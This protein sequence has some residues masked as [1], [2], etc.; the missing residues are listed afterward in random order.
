MRLIVAK[1]SKSTNNQWEIMYLATT[2]SKAYSAMQKAVD[3]QL[4]YGI[5]EYFEFG[6]F[7]DNTNNKAFYYVDYRNKANMPINLGLIDL[8]NSDFT[9]NKPREP[10]STNNDPFHHLLTTK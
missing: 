5:D 6:V 2:V 9:I 10:S 8:V 1:R 4:V 7:K 3:Y